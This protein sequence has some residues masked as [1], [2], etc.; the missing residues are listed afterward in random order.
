MMDDN[1]SSIEI[2][3]TNPG[4]ISRL[5]QDIADY[6]SPFGYR[7][8]TQTSKNVDGTAL[9]TIPG[10][11][12][13][14]PVKTVH[15]Y[16]HAEDFISSIGPLIRTYLRLSDGNL[17]PKKLRAVVDCKFVITCKYATKCIN[18]EEAAAKRMAHHIHMIIRNSMGSALCLDFVV[19]LPFYS[20]ENKRSLSV[21][22][23][24]IA[25]N[26]NIDTNYPCV[27]LRERSLDEVF[28]CDCID[29][30]LYLH[31]RSR[32]CTVRHQPKL[33]CWLSSS[34]LEACIESGMKRGAIVSGPI[35]I[36][37]IEKVANL[38]RILMLC[39]DYDKSA[40]ENCCFSEDTSCE[41]DKYSELSLLLLNVVVAIP[42]EVVNNPGR[43]RKNTKATKALLQY[44]DEAIEHFHSAVFGDSKEQY[45]FYRPTIVN[46]DECI[47]TISALG[48]SN[49]TS[50][51]T[52]LG[53][54]LHRNALTLSGDYEECKHVKNL[55]QHLQQEFNHTYY[56]MRELLKSRAIVFGYESTGI[57]ECIQTYLNA[58]VQISSR[59]SLN[60]VASMAILFD[61]IFRK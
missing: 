39:Y 30:T 16:C 20:S 5:D 46:E 43:T 34:S 47:D 61:A 31:V 50:K 8:K 45:T 18:G 3:L 7:L 1:T 40:L 11:P 28:D 42:K 48:K 57:P 58:W 55:Q 36:A 10:L 60:V 56:A 35:V 22:A 15:I 23:V 14:K 29:G 12:A 59:S 27:T 6:L 33:F 54:D 4:I 38:H 13:I 32:M 41:N 2:Q 44:Y 49:D 37:C 52:L 9:F 24:R 25:M 51:Q 19:V 26:S 21:H 53:I 17:H